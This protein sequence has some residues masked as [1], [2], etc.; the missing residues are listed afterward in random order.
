MIFAPL[1]TFIYFHHRRLASDL[2]QPRPDVVVVPLRH[3]RLIAP[4]DVKRP[5]TQFAR[6]KP[7]TTLTGCPDL[8]PK[9]S[10][11]E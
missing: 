9:K 4:P 8:P 11:T 2:D 10:Q 6:S 7:H 1:K 5:L 3:A